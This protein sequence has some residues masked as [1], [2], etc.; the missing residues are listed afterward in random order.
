MEY[1]NEASITKIKE[2]MSEF[3]AQLRDELGDEKE[4]ANVVIASSALLYVSLV[5]VTM[6]DENDLRKRAIMQL[7]DDT[8]DILSTIDYDDAKALTLLK[9]MMMDIKAINGH[10]KKEEMH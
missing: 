8:S 5:K 6:N 4:A 9:M 2:Y 3:F 10:L 7:T 1:N